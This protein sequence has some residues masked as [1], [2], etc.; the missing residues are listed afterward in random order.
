MASGPPTDRELSAQA[1]SVGDNGPRD[2]CWGEVSVTEPVHARY[3]KQDDNHENG[4][5]D[6]PGVPVGDDVYERVRIPLG[7]SAVD[8]DVGEPC[9]WPQ[10]R[11]RDCSTFDTTTGAEQQ[12]ADDHHYRHDVVEHCVGGRLLPAVRLMDLRQDRPV[13]DAGDR[14]SEQRSEAYRSPYSPVSVGAAGELNGRHATEDVALN[15]EEAQ[16]PQH[17]V[18]RRG[19]A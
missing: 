9:D 17:S 3:E 12:P 4:V 7:D 8:Q 14:D 13:D 15:R 10:H 6:D 2:W 1:S 18:G 19:S 11:Q 16:N 5:D